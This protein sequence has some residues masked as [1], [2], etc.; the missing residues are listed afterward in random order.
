MLFTFLPL[1]YKLFFF[2]VIVYTAF[3][4]AEGVLYS[5]LFCRSYTNKARERFTFLLKTGYVSNLFIIRQMTLTVN[6]IY[7]LILS[8]PWLIVQCL[9]PEILH[10]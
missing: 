1:I 3:N 6:Y 2:T 10:M 5:S 4:F 9:L 7:K 8:L